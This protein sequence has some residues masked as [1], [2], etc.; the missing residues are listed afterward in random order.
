M[1]YPRSPK[2]QRLM[3][4]DNASKKTQLSSS[5]VNSSTKKI[6]P[7]TNSDARGFTFQSPRVA[8]S[9]K[10]KTGLTRKGDLEKKAFSRSIEDVYLSSQRGW[11]TIRKLV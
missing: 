10:S 2:L 6:S 5:I 1:S 8:P 4:L 7:L 3:T 11:T 9:T